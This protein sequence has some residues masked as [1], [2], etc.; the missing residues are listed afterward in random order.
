MTSERQGRPSFFG[1]VSRA[2]RRRPLL[3]LLLLPFVAVFVAGRA[4]VAPL[5]MR[6]ALP[7]DVAADR[8]AA[9]PTAR[10]P[11]PL[12]PTPEAESIAQ[13]DD[14]PNEASVAPPAAGSI[15]PAPGPVKPPPAIGILVGRKRVQAAV[16]AGIRPSG[17]PVPATPWRPAGLA[18][19]GV[20][21][22]GVGLRDGDVLVRAGGTPARSDGAVIG[23][24][25]GALESRARAISGEV[26]RGERRIVI[27]VELP[28]VKF[29]RKR[30]RGKPPRDPKQTRQ[31]PP[32]VGA[33]SRPA[34][35]G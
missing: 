10:E 7:V 27:T 23:A 24:V 14:S 9:L 32:T 1:E 31:P 16:K 34:V 26:W 35:A 11:Q 28:K 8:L 15:R 30:Q 19:A 18:L 12:P 13:L 4:A 25:R 17:T 3:A 2:A 6:L 20:S 21:A 5:A 29:K 22:L 33:V